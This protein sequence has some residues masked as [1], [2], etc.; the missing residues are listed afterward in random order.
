[1]AWSYIKNARHRNSK[2]MYGNLYATRQ[3]ER[4]KMRWLDDASTDLRKMRI[5][6]WRER[7]QGTERLGGVL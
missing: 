4:P 1:M 2:K 3:I 6:E 5:N 7:E